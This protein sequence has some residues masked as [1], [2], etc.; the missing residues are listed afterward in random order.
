MTR[1]DGGLSGDVLSSSSPVQRASF[2][3]LLT[4]LTRSPIFLDTAVPCPRC[5][6]VTEWPRWVRE[7][8]SSLDRSASP[9]AFLSGEILRCRRCNRSSTRA[10][11]E[12]LVAEDGDAV[13]RLEECLALEE[14]NE[15]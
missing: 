6:I 1:Q 9:A 13:R 4:A 11:V 15:G 5:Q 8:R 3:Q 10:L 2:E 14:T 7:T 12:R